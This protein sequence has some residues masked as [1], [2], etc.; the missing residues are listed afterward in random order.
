M[1]NNAPNGVSVATIRVDIP[2]ILMDIK[3]HWWNIL[4]AAL[5][6]VMLMIAF[7]ITFPVEKYS[8]ATVLAISSN[9]GDVIRNVNNANKVAS[10]LTEVMN[11]DILKQMVAGDIGQQIYVTS[12]D[13]ISDTNLITLTVTADSPRLAF[14]A[15]QSILKHYNVLLE[16]LMSDVRLVILQQPVI[17]TAP[18]QAYNLY[19]YAVLAFIAGGAIFAGGIAAL[20]VLRDTVKNITDVKNKVDARLLGTIPFVADEMGKNRI[21]KEVPFLAGEQV[22]FWFKESIQMTASRILNHMDQRQEKVLMFTSVLANEGKTTCAVNMAMAIAQ[23]N[24]R[25]LLIDG[26]FRNPS[27]AV[28]LKIGDDYQNKL[29]EVLGT[30]EFDESMLYQVPNS[31]LY[32]VTN[33]SSHMQSNLSFSNG[34]FE[35]L[36]N[37][38]RKNFDFVVVDSGPVAL[39]ADI[40][41]MKGFCD[42]SVLILAQDAAPVRAINDAVDMLDDQGKLIGCIFKETRPSARRKDAEYG[43]YHHTM[44]EDR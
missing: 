27:V 44:K 40:E 41:L 4:L 10:T 37:Y 25:V 3:R 18:D 15:L 2:S 7:L 30:G 39:V 26:D 23:N 20:S 16:D 29:K 19:V 12:A 38:G 14:Q 22:S 28:A 36:L 17:P 31:Q 1:R 33:Q 11:A 34:H 5:S 42:A 13:Y 24:R 8:A 9:N 32:C 21:R 6:A 35:G 43:S